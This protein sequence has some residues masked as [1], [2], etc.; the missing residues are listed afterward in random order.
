MTLASCGSHKTTT[1]VTP[2]KVKIELDECQ[3]LA[4]AK[5]AI[6]AWG[7]GV[8]YRLSRAT[9]YAE[10]QARARFARSIASA[11]KTAQSEEGLSYDKASTD[12][13][14]G[15]NVRD[16]GSKGNDL[17]QSIA[18]TTVKNAVIIKTSQYQKKDGSYQVFVC[19]EYQD[20]VGKLASDVTKKVQQQVSDE[21]RL[22]MNFEFEKFRQR[23]E[24]EL[25]KSKG[26]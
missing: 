20:G 15:A 9:S 26:E 16:E 3:E 2:D 10:L 1:M 14:N 5:P 12:G 17:A 6:R 13:E 7:E 21:D 23:V 24:D 11:I 25:K 18:E 8:N 22:K 4:Q 19:L